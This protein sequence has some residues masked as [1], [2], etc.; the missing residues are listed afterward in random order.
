MKGSF[1]L[2][3]RREENEEVIIGH[4]GNSDYWNVVFGDT[5]FSFEEGTGDNGLF[6]RV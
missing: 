2:Y 3:V 4:T 5:S 6:W 1:L